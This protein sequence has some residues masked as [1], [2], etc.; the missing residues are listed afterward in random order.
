LLFSKKLLYICEFFEQERSNY[1]HRIN[2]RRIIAQRG[3]GLK[4]FILRAASAAGG[5]YT[6]SGLENKP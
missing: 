5:G 3:K 6:G 1:F 4:I 2:F